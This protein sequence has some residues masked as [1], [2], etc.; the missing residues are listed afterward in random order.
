MNTLFKFYVP[1]WLFLGLAAARMLPALWDA[2]QR[3]P[4]WLRVPWQAAAGVLLAGSLV[5]LAV[6]VR[7]RVDDR[8]PGARPPL[9]TLDATAYMTVGEYTWPD[10]DS[11]IPLRYER[12]A[13]QWLL[14]NVSGT[15]VV[16]EAPAGSYTVGDESVSYDYYRAGGL[17]VASLTGFPTFV[18]QHQY[19]QR[20]GDQVAE[21]TMQAMRL[22]QTTDIA[23][24]RRLLAEL[25]VGY[26]Y[27]GRLER[28]LFS[29][30]ALRK[31]D[32]LVDAGELAAIYRNPDV[33]IYRVNRPG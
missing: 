4:A 2:A 23:E 18:G 3:A 10:S 1:A 7:H 17:R 11:V 9:G 5:F 24:A 21:R 20:P 33:T 32:V 30:D 16:A 27:I 6:G 29:A 26:V 13:I 28:I 25:R 19:E 22:F 14:R 15:P 8:F 12:E 31:F